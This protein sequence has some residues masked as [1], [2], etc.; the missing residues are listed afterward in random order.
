MPSRSIWVSVFSGVVL[1]EL[2][3]AVGAVGLVIAAAYHT[4]HG[5]SMITVLD[6]VWYGA[7]YFPRI[8]ERIHSRLIPNVLRSR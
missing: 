4:R 1:V 3:I 7:Q 5:L 8:I 6:N 2:P